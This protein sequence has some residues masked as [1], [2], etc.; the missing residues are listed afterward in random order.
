MTS[1]RRLL[2]SVLVLLDQSLLV[3]VFP[4]NDTCAYVAH[5]CPVYVPDG[6]SGRARLLTRSKGQAHARVVTWSMRPVAGSTLDSLKPPAPTAAAHAAGEQASNSKRGAHSNASSSPVKTASS[7]SVPLN[8]NAAGPANS[9]DGSEVT[10]FASPA[11][12]CVLV[13]VRACAPR[14]R[15]RSQTPRQIRSSMF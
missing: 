5:T 3:L 12:V 1:C 2:I 6:S 11:V 14:E 4:L 7:A 8:A 10:V 15:C 9:L 13:C